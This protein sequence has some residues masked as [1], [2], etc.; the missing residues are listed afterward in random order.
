MDKVLLDNIACSTWKHYLSRPFDLLKTS[1]WNAWYQSDQIEQLFGVNFS[2]CLFVEYPQGQ[3]RSYFETA[4]LN[5]FFRRLETIAENDLP[6]TERLI[7]KG[8]ENND[9]VASL[10][11]E[12]RELTLADALELIIEVALTG[13]IFPYFAG[14]SLL[15]NLTENH[16]L[17]KRCVDLRATSYYPK[18][19]SELLVPAAKKSLL[20]IDKE[21]GD[22]VSFTTV[23]EILN[24][25]VSL[26]IL[27]E[28]K[29][30]SE[31]QRGFVYLCD[32]GRERVSYTINR[33]TL[34][35]KIDPDYFLN[36]QEI[37][38]V[39]GNKG[40]ASGR[41]KLVLNSTITSSEFNEGNIL[42]AHST[43]P[44]LL[45]IIK[46][47]AAIITDEGG[48]LCHAAVI[49]REL[50]KP[51]IIDTRVATNILQDGDLVE[52]DAINGTVKKISS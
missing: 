24:K 49:A 2:K 7:S 26:D 16:E 45:P 38:G 6:Y 47:A 22:Y 40:F 19:F 30:Y 34:L 13:T 35:R 1:V 9:R 4:T 3:V 15:I 10:I 8:Y 21:S 5:S 27:R 43:N 11:K 23:N 33:D 32:R 25:T 12:R 50:N 37:R 29:K 17:V 52:V 41:V 36:S 44:S 18:V 14:E 51:C 46:R 39:I 31:T 42:V 28:R 48:V 20:E